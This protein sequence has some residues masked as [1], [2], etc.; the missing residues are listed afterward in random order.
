MLSEKIT[1][2]QKIRGIVPAP[3]SG[4]PFVCDGNPEHCGVVVIG[5]NPATKTD[6]DWWSYW[7]ATSGFDLQRFLSEYRVSRVAAGKRLLSNTSLRLARLRQAGL[8]TVETNAYV[9]EAFHGHGRN[10]LVNPVL[11][12]LMVELPLLKAV[13]VHGK[14]AQ[15][16]ISAFRIPQS[17]KIFTLPHF[18]SCSYALVD[19]VARDIL[20]D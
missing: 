6:S 16:V 13:V 20:S 10:P 11:S 4:R 5:D 12:L 15:T 9:N 14:V 3:C 1:F 17:V 2:D 8:H 18:R 19:D 7:D